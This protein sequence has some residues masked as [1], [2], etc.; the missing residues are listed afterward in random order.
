MRSQ[1]ESK[2]PAS[3]LVYRFAGF[4]MERHQ[5]RRKPVGVVRHWPMPDAIVSSYSVCDFAASKDVDARCRTIELGLNSPF[6]RSLLL[7]GWV[8]QIQHRP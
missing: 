4:M 2:H 5:T 6:Y 7:V 3:Q 8:Q 1:L